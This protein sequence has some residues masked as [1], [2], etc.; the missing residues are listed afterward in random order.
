[1]LT[2]DRRD[3]A[4]AWHVRLSDPSASGEIWVAFTEW[5]EADPANADAYDAI[6]LVDAELADTLVAANADPQIPQNDN[7]PVLVPWYKRRSIFAIAASSALAVLFAPVLMSGRDLQTFETKPGETR[8]IALNDGSRIALNGGSKIEIDRN[9]DRYAT[10]IVGEAV[11]TIHHDPA[12]PFELKTANSTFQDVGTIFN[13]RQDDHGLEVTVAEGAVQYNPRAEAVTVSAG[14]RLTVWLDRPTPTI[15]KADPGSV[16]G[17]RQGRL[18]YQEAKL[19]TIA[20]DLSRSLGTPVSISKD[21]TERRFSGLI[22]VD[23]DQA[24]MFRRLESLL[25]VRARHSEKGW[26]LTS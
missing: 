17:W 21:L 10:L 3:D 23:R 13:V 1:V 8:E 4:I 12:N 2:D 7:E 16:A 5:L 22:Q 19:S 9:S 14:N 20:L 24:K 6:A 26:Q 18:T 11:F 15:S 25:G